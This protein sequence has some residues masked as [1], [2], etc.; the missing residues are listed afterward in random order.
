MYSGSGGAGDAGAGSGGAGVA[1]ATGSGGAGVDAVSLAGLQPVPSL[2][3]TLATAT[4][5]APPEEKL[6]VPVAV[7]A[8]LVVCVA[9]TI[10][11]G[12]T[13]LIIDFA[14]QATTIF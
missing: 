1:G 6:V 5:Q 14:R 4:L 3:G 11:G 13:S 2:D 12:V 7:S 8:V 10:V 9:F